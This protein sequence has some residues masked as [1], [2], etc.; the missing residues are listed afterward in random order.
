MVKGV[1]WNLW[2]S[3]SAG[4]CAAGGKYHKISPSKGAA[5]YQ[6]KNLAKPGSRDLSGMTKSS[7]LLNNGSQGKVLPLKSASVIVCIMWEKQ[8]IVTQVLQG[9]LQ[10]L[11]YWSVYEWAWFIWEDV[12]LRLTLKVHS[13]AILKKIYKVM[14]GTLKLVCNTNTILLC[15]SFYLWYFSSQ[16]CNTSRSRKYVWHFCGCSIKSYSLR[17]ASLSHFKSEHHKI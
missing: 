7:G 17:P 11:F 5:L 6:S 14:L 8:F 12:F 16:I 10:I 15:V 2:G 13:I 9:L 3:T 4:V 1:V